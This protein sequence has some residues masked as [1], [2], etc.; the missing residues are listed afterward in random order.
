LEAEHGVEP[1]CK[2]GQKREI[3]GGQIRPY[4]LDSTRFGDRH[5]YTSF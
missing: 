5:H 1:G 2:F 4:M 3:G